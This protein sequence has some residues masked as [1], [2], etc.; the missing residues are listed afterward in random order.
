MAQ[1]L[2]LDPTYL[3]QLENAKREVDDWY[4]TKARSTLTE[5]EKSKPVTVSEKPQGYGSISVAREKCHMH[6]DVFLDACQGDPEKLAWTFIELQQHFPVD[7]WRPRSGTPD[8]STEKAINEAAISGLAQIGGKAAVE[9]LGLSPKV[10][11]TNENTAAQEHR[12]PPE[13]D[14]RQSPA[15]PVP[16][17]HES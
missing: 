11:S 14:D 4:I 9:E 1:A 2:E 15:K 13:K 12:A 10:A 5:F 7:K 8:G 17:E 6:L 16:F 3:S